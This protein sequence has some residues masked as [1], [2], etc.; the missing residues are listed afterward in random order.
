MSDEKITVLNPACSST[1]VER[2]PLAPRT[3]SSLDNKT[4][5]IVDIGW[6]GPKA[7]YDLFE[8]LQIWFNRNMPSLKTILVKKKGGYN[9]D[10]PALWKRIKAE[11]DACIIGLS[12]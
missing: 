5:F 6:G 10:D 8:A 3:F 4:V 9:D 1:L 11:G 7:G 12:C 2:V